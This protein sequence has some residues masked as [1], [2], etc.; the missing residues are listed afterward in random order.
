MISVVELVSMCI[1]I[2]GGRHHILFLTLRTALHTAMLLQSSCGISMLSSITP[3][4]A[5]LLVQK[6]CVSFRYQASRQKNYHT[7]QIKGY[8][9]SNPVP[10]HVLGKNKTT[11]KVLASLP[12]ICNTRTL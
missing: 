9:S 4:K 12:D 8:S 7:G 3:S 1:S 2:L 10:Y 5:T 6:C 11:G